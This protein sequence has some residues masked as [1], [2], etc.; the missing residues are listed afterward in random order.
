MKFK[1][2]LRFL[3]ILL[4]CIFISLCVTESYAHAKT[5]WRTSSCTWWRKKYRAEAG[6]R[7]WIIP[8]PPVTTC[9]SY[10]ANCSGILPQFASSCNDN[11]GIADCYI[12]PITANPQNNKEVRKEEQIIRTPTQFPCWLGEYSSKLYTDIYSDIYRY[13][14]LPKFSATVKGELVIANFTR[15]ESINSDT[16]KFTI[17][18]G[19][20]VI[21]LK[22]D[23]YSTVEMKFTVW[24]PQD[25]YVNS[26]EDT[27]VT[28]NKTIVEEYIMIKAG[29]VEISTGLLN[30]SAIT[31]YNDG[32]YTVVEINNLNYEYTIP[33][34]ANIEDLAVAS[35]VT[36]SPDESKMVAQSMAQSNAKEDETGLIYKVFPNPSNDYLVVE[37]PKQEIITRVELKLFDINGKL[38]KSRIYS[39]LPTISDKIRVELDIKDLS[40]QQYYINIIVND[41]DLRTKKISIIR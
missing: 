26:I 7:H 27:I 18:D 12:F 41:N 4:V 38:V 16:R 32:E 11:C 13:T 29:S 39:D 5:D 10:H 31:S 23:D 40:S 37:I 35:Y 6:I 15:N 24:Q 34:S 20:G 1:F 17:T 9:I 36:T 33:N 25:D 30:N 22:N 19:N 8:L 2:S 28:A 14:I 21:K 3:T